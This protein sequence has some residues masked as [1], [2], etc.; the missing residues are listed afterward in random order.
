MIKPERKLAF[1]AL[2]ASGGNSPDIRQA[3]SLPYRYEPSR[4]M[5]LMRDMYRSTPDFDAS[6]Y[7]LPNVTP[8][9]FEL[10]R[11]QVLFDTDELTIFHGSSLELGDTVKGSHWLCPVIVHVG[12]KTV[13]LHVVMSNIS[14]DMQH[15]ERDLS[16]PEDVDIKVSL[17]T[18][19]ERKLN[20]VKPGDPHNDLLDGFDEKRITIY[21]ITV[22]NIAFPYIQ[23]PSELGSD[24]EVRQAIKQLTRFLGLGQQ[25]REKIPMDL[26][27]DHVREQILP[28]L[29]ELPHFSI[30]EPLSMPMDGGEDI[31]IYNVYSKGDIWELYQIMSY[32]PIEELLKNPNPKM[33]LD[34]NCDTGMLF[35]DKGCECHPQLLSALELAKAEG[36]FVVHAPTQDGRG[37]GNAINLEIERLKQGK[38][39]ITLPDNDVIYPSK[40]AARMIYGPAEWDIRTYYPIGKLLQEMGFTGMGVVTENGNKIRNMDEGSD[41]TIDFYQISTGT[42]E[43]NQGNVVMEANLRSKHLDRRYSAYKPRESAVKRFNLTPI[44]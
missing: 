14:I 25:A 20:V 5:Q 34:S 36:G 4:T 1:Q 27:L 16:N 30:S 23:N 37:F 7:P 40:A 21:P 10:T 8:E 31:L 42:K 35:H 3:E 24:V 44:V 39:S 2:D 22:G 26:S 38:P 9:L 19:I 18:E 15:L 6:L 12:E 41:L 11:E 29:M 13:P 28:T 32:V 17:V 43:K 33:R